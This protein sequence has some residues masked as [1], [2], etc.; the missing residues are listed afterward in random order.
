VKN[1]QWLCCSRAE[2][3]CQKI[4]GAKIV[5]YKSPLA[6]YAVFRGPNVVKDNVIRFFNEIGMQ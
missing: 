2:E 4:P 1:D 5:T 3:S 6:H